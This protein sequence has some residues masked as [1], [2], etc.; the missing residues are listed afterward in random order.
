MKEAEEKGEH[1]DG[2]EDCDGEAWEDEYK[3]FF[4]AQRKK[5]REASET[6]EVEILRNVETKEKVLSA[7]EKEALVKAQQKGREDEVTVRREFMPDDESIRIQ[8]SKLDFMRLSASSP[9]DDEFE[10]EEQAPDKI[11]RIGNGSISDLGSL[12]DGDVQ[13]QDYMSPTLQKM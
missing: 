6:K 9:R 13:L 1:E 10:G 2:E 3:E 4:E 5:D 8:Q 12:R 11:V 7:S